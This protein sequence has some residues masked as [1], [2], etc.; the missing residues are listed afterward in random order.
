MAAVFAEPMPPRAERTACRSTQMRTGA[1][2][3]PRR[4]I[5]Q[6]QGTAQVAVVGDDDKVT[7]ADV[8]LGPRTDDGWIIEKGV[9]VGQRVVVEGLQK[10]RTGMV[11]TPKDATAASSAK[12]TKPTKSPSS[13]DDLQSSKSDSKTGA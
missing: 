7:L 2:V 3:V 8:E 10:V 9:T 12:P 4:A 13:E 5:K 11:V 6:T 1:L